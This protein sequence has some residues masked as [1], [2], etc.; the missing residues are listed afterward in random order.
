[1]K[2]RIEIRLSKE[3][4]NSYFLMTYGRH[5]E[6]IDLT[7]L[8]FAEGIYVSGLRGVKSELKEIFKENPRN[9]LWLDFREKGKNRIG[10]RTKNRLIEMIL[11]HNFLALKQIPS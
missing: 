9:K 6:V 2:Y 11:N 3:E 8:P 5:D 7:R 4:G 1:M 10:K